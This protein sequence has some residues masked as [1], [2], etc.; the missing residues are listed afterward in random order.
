MAYATVRATSAP[1]LVYLR[2][3]GHWS[4]LYMAFLNPT[5]IYRATLASV[6]SSN[7]RVVQVSFTH[8][9]GT[10]AN[11]K[12]DMSL[13]VGTASGAYDL[14]VVRIRKTP[15]A[16][17]FYIGEESEIKWNT[18]GTIH[19]TVVEE[20]DI[21]ARHI[22]TVSDTDFRMDWDVTYTNQNSVFDPVPVMGGHRVLK[23]TGA[24]VSAIFDFSNSWVIGSTI[25]GYSVAC[26][27]SSSI[28]SG[29][30]STPTISFNTNGWHAVYLTVTA[31]N[32][33]TY[34]GMRYVYVYSSAA[35]P[36]TVFQLENCSVDYDTG[37]WSFDVTVQSGI[38]LANVPERALC[39]L[40]AED[41][42][43][44]TQVSIGQL[45]GCE[46]II[47]VGKISEERI[48]V[49]Y[50]QSE[51]TLRVE[52]YH[53]WFNKVQGFPTGVLAV[54]GT[55]ANW[56]EMQEPTVRK[57]LYRLLHWG[58]TAT[59]IM[60]IYLPDD[61]KLATELTSPT[62][63][64]WVQMQELAFSTIM[65]RPGVDRF[66]R[67]FVEVEP[68]VV[69]PASRTWATVM[70]ITKP[71]YYDS[72]NLERVVVSSTGMIDISGVTVTSADNG[73]AL[74]GLAPGHVFKRY[75]N[76]EVVDRL[77]LSTQALTNQMGGLILGWRN[78][79]Y[80]NTE[81]TLLANNRMI[82]CFPRQKVA[83]AL[84]SGENPRGITL[85][86]SYVPR[87]VEFQWDDETLFLET[88][89]SVEME[90]VEDLSVN[91]DIPGDGD[92][93]ISIP[94]APPL[95]PPT[96]FPPIILPG[97]MQDLALMRVL[98]HDTNIGLIYSK[99]FGADFGGDVKYITVNGGLTSS[100][101]RFID[102]IIISP[103]GELYVARRGS[104]GT[105]DPFI[106]Y[107]PY[108]GGTFTILENVA[109]I[110]AKIPEIASAVAWGVNGLGINP[111]TGQIAYVISA[112][113]DFNQQRAKFYLGTGVSFAETLSY[114]DMR[115]DTQG[116]LTYGDG[117][118]RMT[119]ARATGAVSCFWELDGGLTSILNTV[120]V[121][122]AAQ[123]HIPISSTNELFMHDGDFLLR[124]TDNGNVPADF[125]TAIGSLVNS[126]TP[127]EN[128]VAT[129]PTGTMLMLSWDVGQRGRSS[130]GGATI[131]GIPNLTFGGHYAYDYAGGLGNESRWIAALGRVW[132]SDDWGDTWSDQTGNLMTIAPVPSISIIKVVF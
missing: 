126:P 107:A 12:K 17:T 112:R 117:S 50:E 124:I 78:N 38:T 74:F 4:R 91:G 10:L 113:N 101:Y 129:D 57:V 44:D 110:T 63:S 65:A 128:K 67:L 82:D 28:T 109:S 100:Q 49:N 3:M 11:V 80:P 77:L 130:D 56:A 64:L 83:W 102:K 45:A 94:P 72:V 25:S 121:S 123:T 26:A 75:G 1:E 69:P 27:T 46:N 68:Q 58:C 76:T 96:P 22:N 21:W 14:G 16:G 114:T 47:C 118:W 120:P 32:G 53:T 13:Y 89:I 105:G 31:A 92:E 99:N 98:G 79:P 87:R 125:T 88:N 60:D 29:T 119:G 41:F 43:G 66:G 81:F 20:F 37:G 33:K 90:S 111:L 35:M 54:S 106:A 15:I 52:G 95:L 85:N 122:G 5:V 2:T 108:I 51:I 132:F 24:T 61:T 30:T 131:V 7:D 127:W 86:A 34:T 9:S 59:T 104:S 84:A 70:T 48:S 19:L 103:T 6:P 8:V 40:F 62:S 55:P 116:N 73:D 36:S 39:I 93:N 115:Q 71:D 23:L 97:D 18:A 42:Y